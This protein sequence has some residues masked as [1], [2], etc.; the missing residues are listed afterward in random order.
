MNAE[1]PSDRS[2]IIQDHD[3]LRAMVCDVKAGLDRLQCDPGGPEP[4]FA[5]RNALNQMR[6]RLERHFAREE[7]GWSIAAG[8][9]PSTERWVRS[10]TE[11]HRDFEARMRDMLGELDRCLGESTAISPGCDASIR[12][13]LTDLTAHELSE[14]RLLQRAI[15]EELDCA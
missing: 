7:A 13:L 2:T 1:L 9:D 5:M 10:L 6:Q 12:A 11:Q 4:A 3:A 15:F 14:D 8:R